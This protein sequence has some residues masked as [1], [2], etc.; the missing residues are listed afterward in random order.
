MLDSDQ[1]IARLSSASQVPLSTP[2]S[3]PHNP[4]IPHSSILPQ[5]HPQAVYTEV[6]RSL[7]HEIEHVCCNPKKMRGLCVKGFFEIYPNWGR[8]KPH[9]VLR[10]VSSSQSDTFPFCSAHGVLVLTAVRA[11]RG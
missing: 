7:G 4:T 1:F 6:L 8:V 9:F 10:K 3:Q 11:C 5:L 2:K